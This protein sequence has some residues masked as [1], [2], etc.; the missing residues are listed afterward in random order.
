MTRIT[1]ALHL[2]DATD[3]LGLELTTIRYHRA[4]LR[5]FVVLEPTVRGPIPMEKIILNIKFIFVAKQ[6][7]TISN[8]IKSFSAGV[9]FVVILLWIYELSL[10]ICF[11]FII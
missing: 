7:L 6:I 11:L 5:L 3:L 10:K 9:A 2:R 1:F 4:E 8:L